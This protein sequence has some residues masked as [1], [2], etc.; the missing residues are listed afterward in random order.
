[1]FG[2]LGRATTWLGPAVHGTR[3]KL[4]LNNWL[5]DLT[6]ATAEILSFARRLGLDP[7]GIVE[8]LQSTPL[9]APYAVQQA[10]SMLAGD[11][12]PAFALKHA[13]KDAE[14]S[15]ASRAGQRRNPDPHQRADSSLA[16]HRRL[17]ARR[18]RPVRRL[19][20]DVTRAGWA[21]GNYALWRALT[22]VA[23]EN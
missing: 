20:H 6:G 23:A 15:R 3:A 16:G 18:R 5:A 11:F 7:A 10:H 12:R 13:L 21:A 9:G 8:L 2:A 1:M 19:S 17:R 14:H 4:V 22:W